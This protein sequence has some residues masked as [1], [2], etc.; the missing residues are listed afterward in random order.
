[1]KMGQNSLHFAQNA[2][3]KGKRSHVYHPFTK[4]QEPWIGLHRSNKQ[5]ELLKKMKTNIAS[6]ILMAAV[7]AGAGIA[8]AATKGSDTLG[9]D[10]LLAKNV[11]HE[12]VM[13]PNYTLW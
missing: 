8:G 7:L 6:R 2:I 5:K 3:R 4:P 12:V 11:R 10:A 13:Y 9:G 1:M